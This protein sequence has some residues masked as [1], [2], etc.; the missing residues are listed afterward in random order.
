MTTTQNRLPHRN[1]SLSRSLSR[2]RLPHRNKSL[3]R[4]LSRSRLLRGRLLRWLW[5]RVLFRLW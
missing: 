3:L 2:N 5:G 1:K 4:S